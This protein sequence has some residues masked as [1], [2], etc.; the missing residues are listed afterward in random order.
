MKKAVFFLVAGLIISVQA[1]SQFGDYTYVALKFGM[2]HGIS[3]KPEFNQYK[4]LN[5]P[6][7][8]MQLD[9]IGSA[10]APGFVFDFLVHFDFSDQAGVFTGIEYNYG[11]IGAKYVTKYEYDDYSMTEINRYHTIGV[12]LA[13][14]IGNKDMADNQMYVYAGGQV[15][16]IIAMS[17]VQRVNWTNKPYS[18]T[19]PSDA[20]NKIAL[21]FL[22]GVN[23]SAFNLELAYYPN[24][25]FNSTYRSDKGFNSYLGQ[26]DKSFS[27]KTS[28][29]IPYGWLSRK[30]YW[31]RKN[32]RNTFWR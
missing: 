8:E 13:L 10:Y 24:S 30:S 9:P 22:V 2:S 1:Y 29:N 11:G 14:K 31:W 12:P 26:P 4:Y 23:F 5:T 3:S 15:N 25:F 27:L 28:I 21:N 20:H 19:I 16:M 18:E 6:S 7:G 32:L 17:S